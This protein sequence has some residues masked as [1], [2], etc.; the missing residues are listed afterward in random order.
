M[1]GKTTK[2]LLI[3]IAQGNIE[4]PESFNPTGRGKP[5]DKAKNQFPHCPGGRIPGALSAVAMRAMAVE[6]SE[7]YLNVQQ[8]ATDVDAYQRGFAT[9][10]EDA[11][12]IGHLWLMA[13]RHKRELLIGILIWIGISL[14]LQGG[15][16]IGTLA[17]SLGVVVWLVVLVAVFSF[18]ARTR[19]REQK[20]VAA[21]A[22][23]LEERDR[24]TAGQAN[25][26][27]ARATAQ[28]E[29]DAMK[30]QLASAQLAV[31]NARCQA[32]EGP[33]ALLALDRVPEEFR[34]AKWRD[35]YKR[36]QK[37]S[38]KHD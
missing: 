33:D 5:A 9:S 6:K 35:L 26:Q 4:P 20:A 27:K 2:E 31:A 15:K 32:N 24:A 3:N 29:L 25:A 10:A 12:T 11:S 30:A 34:A 8:L 1:S 16:A 28:Q 37:L 19:K 22:L 36:A 14:A 17:Q 18:F 7:R 13:N 38:E 23:A 21:S